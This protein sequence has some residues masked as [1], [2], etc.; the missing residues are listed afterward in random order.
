MNALVSVRNNNTGFLT[1]T[2][3]DRAQVKQ[4]LDTNA[5]TSLGISTVK[6]TPTDVPKASADSSVKSAT[7]IKSASG[8]STSGS[9]SESVMGKDTFLQLLVLQMQNQDPMAPTD[10][11]QML[12]QLA[13]FSALE[14]T[15]NLNE[16][17]QQMSS[18][19]DQLNFMSGSQMLGKYVD[20]VDLNGDLLSGTVE[21]VHLDGSLVVL[22]VGGTLMSMAGIIRI[23]DTAPTGA[24]TSESTA[25]S[26]VVA[27]PESN[28]TAKA[29]VF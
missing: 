22:N 4:K 21:S 7:G 8:T 15:T 13:Q 1:P 9:V 16:S 6:A 19:I 26:N 28:S 3:V 20:G 11:N 29:V 23:Q 10:N 17:F 25:T 12:A 27:K 2:R 18:N 24:T 5:A 14:A